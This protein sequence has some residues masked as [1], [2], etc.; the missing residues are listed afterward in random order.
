MEYLD[1]DTGMM[2]G[3]TKEEFIEKR[4]ELAITLPNWFDVWVDINME[5][6]MAG[7]QVVIV[8]SYEELRVVAIKLKE[9]G[10][11]EDQKA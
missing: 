7:L 2:V 5:K 9:T 8:A 10:L 11:A 3:L 6:K 4:R 1:E